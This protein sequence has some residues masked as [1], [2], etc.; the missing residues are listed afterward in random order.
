MYAWVFQVVSFPQVSP[1][2]PCMHLSSPP[3]VPQV[4]PISVFLTWSPDQEVCLHQIGE[5]LKKR[6]GVRCSR[7]RV[8]GCCNNFESE[9]QDWTITGDGTASCGETP[10]PSAKPLLF[11]AQPARV[12]CSN[13]NKSI[14]LCNEHASAAGTVQ[15]RLRSEDN[16][17]S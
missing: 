5:I 8:V 6:L 15:P 12:P 13:D 9:T 7:N 16:W 11:L 10:R 14:W 3:Y 4:L 17:E 2:K 1:L